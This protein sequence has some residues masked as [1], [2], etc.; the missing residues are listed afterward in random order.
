MKYDFD[1]HSPNPNLPIAS[2]KSQILA[3]VRNNPFV[4]VQGAT[5]CGKTTQVP[6]YIIDDAR[7]NGHYCNI[8]VAQPRRIAASSNA[9]RVASER[10]W[11]ASSVVGYQIGSDGREN[12]SDDTRILFCTTGILLEKLIRSKNFANY[13]H[14]ILDEV[15]ERNKDMDFL[16]IVI[17]K[18]FASVSPKTNVKVILMSATIESR[19]V[20]IGEIK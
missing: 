15:H 13:T 17:R 2:Y 6:Q 9:E 4:I 20:N 8:V 16:F 7:A 18:L 3:A 11:P 12:M 1:R 10:N 14:L 19:A 5:G